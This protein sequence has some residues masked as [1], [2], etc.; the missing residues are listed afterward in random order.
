LY[1]N[2]HFDGCKA[3]NEPGQLMA[4]PMLSIQSYP[5]ASSKLMLVGMILDVEDLS[6]KNAVE[7]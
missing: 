5:R 2:L 6:L 3:I 7:T 1:G 4:A